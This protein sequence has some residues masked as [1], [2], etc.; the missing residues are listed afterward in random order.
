MMTLVWIMQCPKRR[1][2][3]MDTDAAEGV[4]EAYCSMKAMGDAD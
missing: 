1:V 4:E 3:V 2:L